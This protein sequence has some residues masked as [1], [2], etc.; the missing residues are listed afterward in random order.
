M[1]WLP[2]ITT[3][4]IKKKIKKRVAEMNQ[5]GLQRWSTF[6]MPDQSAIRR[7]P[8]NFPMPDQIAIWWNGNW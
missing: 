6:P 1:P 3:R 2:T 8:D 7:L 4:Q 5:M